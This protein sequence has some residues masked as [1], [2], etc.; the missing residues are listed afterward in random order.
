MASDP[1]V[2]EH[3]RQAAR[4][5]GVWTATGWAALGSA[6]AGAV[7]TG[8][9]GAVSNRDILR[10][11]SL[12]VGFSTPACWLMA[13]RLLAA[14]LASVWPDSERKWLRRFVD[15]NVEDPLTSVGYRVGFVALAGVWVALLNAAS[16]GDETLAWQGPAALALLVVAGVLI[17]RR[18]LSAMTFVASYLTCVGGAGVLFMVADSIVERP[19]VVG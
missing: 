1:V 18:W 5:A 2:M 16:A 8:G 14:F 9:D 19:F 12:V 4:I 11:V 17:V 7:M 3:R 15:A 13:D 10:A 6:V